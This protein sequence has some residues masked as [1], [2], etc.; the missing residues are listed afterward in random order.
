MTQTSHPIAEA[1]QYTTRGGIG[2]TRESQAIVPELAIG[3]LVQLLDSRRGVLLSSGYDYPGRYTR[4][5]LG[6]VDPPLCVSARERSFE[7]E[8]LNKRG[9]PLL[10]GIR[11]HL[12]GKP[13]L[14]DLTVQSPTSLRGR[15]R[16]TQERFVEEHRSR[17]P[18]VFSVLRELVALFSSSKDPHLGLYGA[19]GYDLCFQFE[20]VPLR[21]ARPADQRDLVLYL[22]D[23]LVVV[24]RQKERASR[25]LYDFEFGGHDSRGHARFRQAERPV[26]PEPTERLDPARAPPGLREHRSA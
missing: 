4:W 16:Q 23:N 21:H 2:V 8:A 20:P 12:Q 14:D 19:F 24:D 6:F 25:L 3:E 18:S 17:Q 13:F 1:L 11:Q 7:I 26:A 9:L 22:P 15:V 5:D 10:E